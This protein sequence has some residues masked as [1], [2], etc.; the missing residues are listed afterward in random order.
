[1]RF[2]PRS[3]F[4]ILAGLLAGATLVLP[5]AGQ[6]PPRER[7]SGT[8]QVTAVDLILS[9]RDASGKVPDDLT[10]ADFE[11]L[12]DGQVRTIVGLEPFRPS[13]GGEASG[14]SKVARKAVTEEP[15]WSWQTV[16]YFDQTLSSSRSIRRAASSLAAQAGRLTELG[17]VQVIVAG[18][19]LQEVLRPTRSA[20]LVEQSLQRIS[21]EVSGQDQLRRI[22]KQF[23]QLAQINGLNSVTI[24][25]VEAPMFEEAFLLR[26]QH[27][28]LLSWVSE[29]LAEGPRALV[30]VNDGYDLDPREFYASSISESQLSDTVNTGNSVAARFNADMASTA[31]APKLRELS[32]FLA[33]R[34]WVTMNLALGATESAG[35]VSAEL[36]GRGRL[37]DLDLRAQTESTA[38]MASAVVYRPLGPL[39]QMAQATGG[40]TLTGVKGL[41]RAL[42]RLTER[43]RLT[44]Q[45]SR[46]P[47]GKL[48]PVEVRALRPGLKVK[49][50]RWS[51]SLSPQAVSAARARRL[52]AGGV[53][54]GGID[55]EAALALGETPEEGGNAKGRL[56]ARVDLTSLAG[57]EMSSAAVRMT[58]A[59]S[60]SEGVPF[61]HHQ[62]LPG[63]DL[64]GLS[65]WTY[66]S[67]I[68]LPPE[69]ERV[70]VVFEDLA[71]GAWGGGLAA[72][73]SELLPPAPT[74]KGQRGEVPVA[75]AEGI[76][77]LDLLPSRKVITLLAPPEEVVLG[78]TRLEVLAADPLIAR[79][80]YWLDGE[81]RASRDQSPFEARLDF[82]NLPQ[83]RRVEAVAYDAGGEELGRDLL[84]VNQGVGVFRVDL[85][86]PLAGRRIGGVDVEADV[87]LPS[88]QDLDRLELR[89]NN[90]TVATLYEPP[91]RQRIL[92][93]ADSPVGYLQAVAFLENGAMAEDVVLLNGEG[94]TEEVSVELV[95]LFT[96]VDDPESR[97]I[98]GL[99][100]EAFRVFEDER[101]QEIADFREGVEV[102]LNL[103]LLVDTSAS[104]FPA[105][106]DVQVTAIDFLSLALRA[107]DRAMVVEFDEKPRLA[108]ALTADRRALMAAIAELEA[109]GRSALCDAM[110]FSLLQM[111]QVAG[112][113]ALVI[114]TDGVGRDERV[115]F[116]VCRRVVERSGIP[117][118]TVLLAGDDPTA[119]AAGGVD[120][121]KVERLVAPVGGRVL[122]AEDPSR[123]GWAYR[124]ILDD[125]RSQYL[126]TY[127]PPSREGDD[128][129]RV[130]VEVES[131][132]A[133]ARTRAGY[134]P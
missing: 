87:S 118:Y 116:D 94:L 45:V 5:T 55:L 92:V 90:D 129:R 46:R 10:P 109:G 62:D 70:A 1:M 43:V 93:P 54:D 104:M 86:E 28:L 74:P 98:R 37:G 31:A 36:S 49:A 65:F 108:Q 117:I 131:P 71:S 2:L 20:R 11:V 124:T 30:L 4:T 23:L 76:V 102:P 125:L 127:Y 99:E 75:G 32:Q 73:V 44:Y 123:L 17:P 22:R 95:E 110:V 91:F 103:A 107:Q 114:L 21:R 6:E 13:P 35:S 52:L 105:M 120:R 134:Y 119:L 59:A 60:F 63:Q 41:P 97:P 101:R 126:L 26:R 130:R 12:E 84:L 3:R 7:F 132:G 57:A 39:N 133:M 85:I 33:A 78:K 64:A 42:E 27:D 81:R 79:V 77:P 25:T 80:E 68:G 16:V 72:R 34:G 66:S 18:S 14:R 40:E 112:R 121:E 88:D 89:W 128:W 29:S 113:R 50:P 82:G 24:G 96:V 51:G 9:V 19:E 67:A 58:I 106:R 69:V 48:H 111:Q 8:A 56:Q 115:G 38:P 15:A 100:A 61:V 53:A 47:D 83:P 122:L